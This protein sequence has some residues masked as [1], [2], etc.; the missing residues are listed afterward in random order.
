MEYNEYVIV[1]IAIGLILLYLVFVLKSANNRLALF[2]T[3]NIDLKNKLKKYE[4]SNTKLRAQIE[5]LELSIRV[6]KEAALFTEHCESV[7]KSL[8]IEAEN[9]MNIMTETAKGVVKDTPNISGQ[10]E[11]EASSLLTVPK[12]V[13]SEKMLDEFGI[14]KRSA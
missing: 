4:N 13:A 8:N 3:T 11:G 6:T 7:A 1:S 12:S 10:Q 9:A 2:E 5:R 14:N